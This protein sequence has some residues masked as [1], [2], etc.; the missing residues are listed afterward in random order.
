MKQI[1]YHLTP[2]IIAK[3]N[4]WKKYI[5]DDP[6]ASRFT[7]TKE[8]GEI[9]NISLYT[10]IQTGIQLRMFDHDM[11]LDITK[12]EE[13]ALR[14]NKLYSKCKTTKHWSTE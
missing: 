3:S 11:E 8:L 13:I 6:Y 7:R 9:S 12:E 5:K 10:D 2:K 14:I 4:W 1:L